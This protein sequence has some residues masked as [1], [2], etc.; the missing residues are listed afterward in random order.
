MC[1][2][3]EDEGRE[4]SRAYPIS[5]SMYFVLVRCGTDNIVPCLVSTLIRKQM[6]RS[7]E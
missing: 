1:D 5:L 6:V 2:L 4:R 7:V 3:C